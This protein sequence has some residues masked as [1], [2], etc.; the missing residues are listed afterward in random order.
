MMQLTFSISLAI[1]L[2]FVEILDPP[3]MH[4]TGSFLFFI[5]RFIAVISFFN[6]GPA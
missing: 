2:I 5:I 6:K 3:I 1:T 4:V